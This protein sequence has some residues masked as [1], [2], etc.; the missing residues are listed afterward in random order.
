MREF[1]ALFPL[2][3]SNRVVTVVVVVTATPDQR[4]LGKQWLRFS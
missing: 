1:V 4:E 2:V 3:F